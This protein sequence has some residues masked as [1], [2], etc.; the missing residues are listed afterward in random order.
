MT[1][2]AEVL[3]EARSLVD[4]PEKWWQQGGGHNSDDCTC[5]DL[6]I[7]DVAVGSDNV[8][9]LWPAEDAFCRA[10]D[11]APGPKAIYVWNDAPERTHADVLAAFDKAIALAEAEEA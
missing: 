9:L 10:I 2:V 4:A 3:R 7:Q 8:A 1:S 6:A 5:A 11:L